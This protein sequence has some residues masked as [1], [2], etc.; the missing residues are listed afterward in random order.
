LEDIHG[1]LL[2]F[3]FLEEIVDRVT[4]TNLP[5]LFA[6]VYSP[7][8][9]YRVY[10]FSLTMEEGC[11]CKWKSYTCRINHF[12]IRQCMTRDENGTDIFQL[13]SRPNPFRG[14]LNL[15]ISENG[16]STSDTVSISE[17]LNRIFMMLI[18]NRILSGMVDTI[19]IQIRIQK[20]MKT[21]VISMISVRI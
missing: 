4:I 7:P 1:L 9:A 17:Y 8:K 5:L 11:N 15:F 12:E 10:L 14:G 20:K 21:N 19:R 3:I 16:Y 2:C 6:V 18:S 13:Y